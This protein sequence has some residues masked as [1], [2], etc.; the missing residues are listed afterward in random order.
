MGLTFALFS[1]LAVAGGAWISQANEIGRTVALIFLAIFGWS[2]IFPN[3][4][5]RLISPLVDVGARLGQ[6]P[7]AGGGPLGSV[8]VGV[9]TG[10]L[11][12]PCAGPILGLVLT[13]AAS[14][15]NL[16]YSVVLL[17]TYSLGAVTSLAAAL[18]AGNRFF[19][20][21]KRFLGVDQIIKKVLGVAVLCGVVVIAF[22]LDRR[23]L[24]AVAKVESAGLEGSLLKF[25]G[26]SSRSLAQKPMPG[27]DGA[28]AWINSPALRPEDLRGKVVLV[29]FWTYSC[30]NCL[31]TLPF[32]EN[33]AADYA[34]DGLVVVGVHTP[35]FAF[36]KNVDNV[37]TAVRDLQIRYPVVI[38]PDYKIWQRFANQFWPNI[39]SSIAKGSFAKSARA[40]ATTTRPNERSWSS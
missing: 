29:D 7:P 1:A 2:L 31:R 15:R 28:S 18:I 13:G 38:D 23:Y 39:T 3:F 16:T 27:F 6:R 30:I 25:A 20:T 34:D 22:K 37:R 32:I 35:E 4:F 11:W 8:L 5:G 19:G 24:T 14:Q 10:L 36:E 40:K 33:W 12:A 21:L 26:V 17:V 9:G